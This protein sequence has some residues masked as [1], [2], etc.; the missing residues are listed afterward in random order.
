MIKH[1]ALTSLFRTLLH[2]L[3]TAQIR[4][5]ALDLSEFAHR[6]MGINAMQNHI[7]ALGYLNDLAEE[8]GEPWFRMVCDLAAVSGVS[9]LDQQTL[10]TVFALYTQKASYL[11]IKAA[12]ASPAAAST[13][14]LAD[15][16]EELSGFTNFK[17]LGS[18][19]Q[20]GF[21]KRITVVF[22]A[23]GS[24]KSSLCES[25]KALANPGLPNRPLHNVRGTGT[26]TPGFCYKF[27]SD[28]EA[29]CVFRR[30]VT[31]VSDG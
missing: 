1:A 24:G 9:T 4:V 15:F 25:L 13:M 21:K 3:M 7:D 14:S 19:L 10:G 31:A 20:I 28:A 26:P 27:K 6:R 12:T 29:Q 23:N 22:G 8:V 5:H 30:N 18:M 11:G 2:Q 16:L 17:L